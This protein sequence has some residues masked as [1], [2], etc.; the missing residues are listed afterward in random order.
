MKYVRTKS[1]AD[2]VYAYAEGDSFPIAN[3]RDL[4]NELINLEILMEYGSFE[5]YEKEM[6]K[7]YGLGLSKTK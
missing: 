4:V 5:N 1:I 2:L 3:I 7:L 6:D